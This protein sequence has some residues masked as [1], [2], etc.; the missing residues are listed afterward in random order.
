MAQLVA[1]NLSMSPSGNSVVE[2][3]G[4]NP[5]GSIHFCSASGA[6]RFLP[7]ISFFAVVPV[8]LPSCISCESLPARKA[9]ELLRYQPPALPLLDSASQSFRTRAHSASSLLPRRKIQSNTLPRVSPVKPRGHVLTPIVISNASI[10]SQEVYI[11]LCGLEPPEG[12]PLS[13][14]TPPIAT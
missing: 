6:V 7:A 1:R 10:I 9:I 2:V 14:P 4:S 8:S 3:S 13:G 12:R 5:D 11:P